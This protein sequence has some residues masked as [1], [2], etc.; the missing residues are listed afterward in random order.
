[1]PWTRDSSDTKYT[2]GFNSILKFSQREAKPLT[3]GL[4]SNIEKF[5][6]R[7]IWLSSHLHGH[8]KSVHNRLK[9]KWDKNTIQSFHKYELLY[10]ELICVNFQCR[11]T[12]VIKLNGIKRKL[13]KKVK[14]NKIKSKHKAASHWHYK[15]IPTISPIPISP[16]VV[17]VR[18][19]FWL[20]L[21]LVLSVRSLNGEGRQWRI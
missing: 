8:F 6:I 3:P 5:L 16:V 1:M 9:L 21:T 15:A 20:V 10:F 11:F 18:A 2:S 4:S 17:G 13:Y 12:Y 14:S 7:E 19:P